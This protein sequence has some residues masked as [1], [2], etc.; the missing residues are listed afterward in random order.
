MYDVQHIEAGFCSSLC[1]HCAV[2]KPPLAVSVKP[3]AR[4]E[5]EEAVI[6]LLSSDD[7]AEAPD[8]E[9]EAATLHGEISPVSFTLPWSKLLIKASHCRQ[10]CRA[11]QRMLCVL[12]IA[13]IYAGRNLLL[14]HIGQSSLIQSLDT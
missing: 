7:E 2:A 3:K 11:H 6:D 13:K 10:G 8:E 12:G 9:D 14:L 5:P 1:K 4:K